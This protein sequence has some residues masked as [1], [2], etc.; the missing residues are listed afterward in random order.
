MLL[1][2]FAPV[3]QYRPEGTAAGPIPDESIVVAQFFVIG[4]DD[5]GRKHPPPVGKGGVRPGISIGFVR[6]AQ[7]QLPSIGVT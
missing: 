1:Q 7:D 5:D 3:G 4:I 6:V 2:A